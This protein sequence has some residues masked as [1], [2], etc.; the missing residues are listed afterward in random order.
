MDIKKKWLNLVDYLRGH[1]IGHTDLADISIKAIL[2]LLILITVPLIFSV[3]KAQRYVDYKIGSIS[4][5]KVVAPF[6]F[7]IL[8]KEDEL[9]KEREEAVNKIPYYFNYDNEITTE[10]KTKL[11]NVFQYLLERRTLV[12]SPDSSQVDINIHA[13]RIK[14][15]LYTKY[16]VNTT[17]AN[18]KIVLE[19]LKSKVYVDHLKL[20]LKNTNDYIEKGILDTTVTALTRPNVSVIR[21]GVEES[22]PFEDRLDIP[23][24]EKIIENYLLQ[25]FDVNQTFI[26]KYF[27]NQI[28]K[29]NLKYDKELTDQA[30]ENA[31]NSISLTKDMVY[32]NERIVDANERID[33]DIY[34]K[35]YSLDM[36]RMEQNKAEGSWQYN[37]A[38]LGKMM[39]LTS[40]VLI[41]GLY[42]YSFRKKI[43]NDNK[44]LFMIVVIILLDLILAAII[45]GPLNWPG[46]VIPTTIASML[47]AILIDS[48]IAF[49]GTV[50]IALILGGIQGGGYDIALITIVSG[51][52]S[53][54]SVHKIRTRNQVFKAI[55]YIALAYYWIILSLSGLRFDSLL[56]AS[57]LFVIYLLPNAVLS[58]FITF[59]VLGI[60]EKLFDITT[61]VT[62]LELSDLNHP[63]LKRL[64]LEAPGTF[65]HSMVVGNLTE[66]AA[67]VIN[68]NSLLARVGSYYHDIG[69]M[70]KP[71]YFVENQM[72]ADNR[73][74]ALS[75]NMSA[76]ILASH[77]KNGIDMAKRYGI[78]KLIR[79]FIPEH[80]G[81]STMRYFYKK[82][83]DSATDGEVNES[84]FKYPGP[85]PQSKE[86]GITMLA[87]AVEAATRSLN[88]PTPSKLR[89]F[90]E[91]LVDERFKEGQ[92]DECDLTLR[93]LKNIIDAFMP[94]LYG[95]FQHRI[96]YP[97]QEKKKPKITGN[98][99]S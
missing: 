48:G 24:L 21:E 91:E 2:F 85:K 96:E 92:L 94:V 22:L 67:K 37:L 29:A 46:Y 74:E 15:E 82:A 62:L 35:L 40:I 23:G 58:P 17:V 75:P 25:K 9:K 1:R 8:K 41:A 49:V 89:A 56:E 32:E 81:T 71:E 6:N 38:F 95:V 59:M 44:K 66:S 72:D 86:T 87:D 79:D 57:R 16:N 98:K 19:L 14:D 42:L 76:L 68:A 45:S 52:V 10:V 30:V 88:N 27:F 97:D 47:L 83:L 18:I 33:E 90:V 11:N 26:F 69:K 70:E 36:A 3:N 77:V 78:P 93:D 60:F 51:M 54:F 64:S 63:L 13:Q 12:I 73:H 43:Y 5:K 34:Q 4:S 53:I 39:L 84:D 65:H 99:K 50:V 28:I 7:F 61:D 80:H 55:I 31:R 20:I